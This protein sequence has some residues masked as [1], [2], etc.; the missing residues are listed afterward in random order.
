MVSKNEIKAGIAAYS[1]EQ[2]S[3]LA[4]LRRHGGA[5]T[6]DQFD[7]EYGCFR[8]RLSTPDEVKKHG[9]RWT[10][11]TRSPNTH[12]WPVAMA[13]FILGDMSGGD[14]ARWLE[15][16]QCMVAIGTVKQKGHKPN[17]VYYLP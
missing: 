1:E 10:D 5:I 8:R 7:D 2:A 17:I 13:S 15:L 16:L 3:L 4:L 14:W 11:E 9:C 12:L 6:Q